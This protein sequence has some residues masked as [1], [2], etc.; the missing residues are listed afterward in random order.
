VLSERTVDHHVGAILRKLG[1][2]GRAEASAEAV[3]L[4]LASRN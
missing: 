3:R 2:R 4:G 1:V